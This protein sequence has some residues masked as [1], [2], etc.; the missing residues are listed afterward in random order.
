[1]ADCGFNGAQSPSFDPAKPGRWRQMH[2]LLDWAQ[3]RGIKL[4]SVRPRCGAA[5]VD[6]GRKLVVPPATPTASALR[7]RSRRR[8]PG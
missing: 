8:E 6:S 3:A 4:D 1:V 7:S 2:R 5:W